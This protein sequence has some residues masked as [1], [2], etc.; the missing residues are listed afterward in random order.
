MFNR[1]KNK[2]IFIFICLCFFQNRQI[3][4]QSASICQ[5][6][7]AVLHMNCSYFGTLQ[8]QQS[9]DMVTWSIIN[10]AS[11]DSI[12]VIPSSTTYYRAIFSSGTCNLVYSDTAVI[13]I[14]S[15][16]TA[17]A[18][19]DINNSCGA[20][21]ATLAGNVPLVGIGSWSVVSG[22]ATIT[23]P[24][25]PTSG[26]T[27]LTV[28]GTATLHWTISNAPCTASFDDVN[29]VTNAIPLAP[30]IA[31][32]TVSATQ[33]VWNWN[34]VNGATGYKYNTV[35]D[36]NTATD[37]GVN[38]S[39]TQTGLTCNTTYTLYVWAY[40]IYSCHSSSTT[41]TQSTSPCIWS[42]CGT[43]TWTAPTGITSI[44]V[45]AWG[46]G[47][48][49]G[50]SGGR[51]PGWCNV[52]GG[53]CCGGVG[54]SGGGGG[55]G[56]NTYTVVP[57]NTYTIIVGCGG[58]AGPGGA[59]YTGSDGSPGGSSYFDGVLW[60]HGGGQ[61]SGGNAA[62]DNTACPGNYGAG[63]AGG[64]GASGGV[65]VT[66]NSG[67]IGT[68]GSSNI[69]NGLTAGAGGNGSGGPVCDGCDYCQGGYAGT[70]GQD[71]C[72]RISY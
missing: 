2:I 47:G 11:L 15:P 49:P 64:T 62:D 16:T 71:G 14:S 55:Y 53:C 29:I 25:S 27:G 7:S 26:V 30:P 54:G 13:T 18:G 8:W 20:D 33:I 3:R 28:P 59:C 66:G 44:T 58:A 21:T 57:G 19:S 10:G 70:N 5:G 6:D 41:L 36:Y 67:V 31:T 23:T 65:D 9:S 22:T 60:A 35:N 46:G 43:F 68:G 42:S 45:E 63:G 69:Y 38:I 4:A 17:N 39:F 61:G 51:P 12:K 56:R 72:V 52:C 34:V 37:N 50:A 24:S 48:G 32:N 40:D 1:K